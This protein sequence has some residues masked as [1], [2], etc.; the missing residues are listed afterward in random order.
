MDRVRDE[1]PIERIRKESLDPTRRSSSAEAGLQFLARGAS[2]NKCQRRVAREARFCMSR[3]QRCRLMRPSNEPVPVCVA[4]AKSITRTSSIV[5]VPV[6]PANRPVPLTMSATSLGLAIF[7]GMNS[8]WAPTVAHLVAV[9]N[10]VVHI[11]AVYRRS[12]EASEYR[13]PLGCLAI[14]LS[15]LRDPRPR[16]WSSSREAGGVH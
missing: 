11:E 3:P 16:S 14:H 2:N 1:N 13:A 12:N 7:G 9:L 8:L 15:R 6:A 10:A 5:N 4:V